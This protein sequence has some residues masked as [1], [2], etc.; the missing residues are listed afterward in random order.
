MIM[1]LSLL[2]T[3]LYTIEHLTTSDEEDIQ[4]FTINN[5]NGQGLLAYLRES[6]IKEELRETA[7]TYL[8]R[9]KQD[10]MIVGYFTLKAGYIAVKRDLT[11]FD[12]VSGIELACFAVNDAY[13]EAHDCKEQLGKY[14]FYHF[15]LPM[16]KDISNSLGACFLYI[17]AL[18]QK[19]LMEYYKTLGFARVSKKEER[20]IHKH[21][22]P[23]FDKG[24]IFMAQRINSVAEQTK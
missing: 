16:V 13:R 8:V 19:K 14:I 23:A 5:K 9:N 2:N 20:Y 24:C 12:A 18:N 17:F 11:S 4:Q 21:S 6:A 7:R 10:N 15:V 1:E 3:N 22:R